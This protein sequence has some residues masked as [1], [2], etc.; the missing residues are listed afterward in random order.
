MVE[1]CSLPPIHLGPNSGGGNED[2]G[3]HPQKTPCMHCYN[4]CP[5]P[6]SG[7]HQ[8]TAPLETPGHYRQVWVSLLGRSLLLS[9][10]SW[11]TRFC[12]C[13]QRVYFPVLCKFWQLYVGLMVTSSKRAYAIPTSAAP[14]APVPVAV[15]CW[16]IPPQEMLKHK[17][18]SIGL[19]GVHGS[20]CT[21][22]LLEPS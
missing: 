15:L 5:Q 6:C 12:L 9:P 17:H 11:C 22:G 7:H 21:Q 2:N 16:P 10:G 8:P 1:L 13:P 19:C 20:W 4:Q 14:R 3:D 18:S